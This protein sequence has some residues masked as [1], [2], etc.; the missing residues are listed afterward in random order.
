MT[1]GPEYSGEVVSRSQL[2]AQANGQ[3]IDENENAGD[4]GADDADG[5]EDEDDD[6]DDET[7][8]AVL[9]ESDEID[10]D[11][12]SEDAGPS[13]SIDPAKLAVC[14]RSTDELDGMFDMNDC[15]QADQRELAAQMA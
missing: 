2:T 6:D 15:L 9:D 14:I 5:A 4:E 1:L 8:G 3:S 10:D 11:E 7:G 13:A 12:V